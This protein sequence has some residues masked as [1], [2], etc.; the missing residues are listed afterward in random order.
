MWGDMGRYGEIW[1]DVGRYGEGRIVSCSGPLGGVRGTVRVRERVRVRMRVRPRV[2]ARVRARAG[3]RARAMARVRVTVTVRVTVRVR[4]ARLGAR[5][6][7]EHDHVQRPLRQARRQLGVLARLGE[8]GQMHHA[9]HGVLLV[10][11][12]LEI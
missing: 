12:H 6:R 3:G 4:V 9:A 10:E 7:R 11:A 2:R 5:R 8:L 1:G